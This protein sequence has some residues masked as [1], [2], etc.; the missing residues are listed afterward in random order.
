MNAG[1]EGILVGIRAIKWWV[2]D[3]NGQTTELFSEREEAFRQQ[4]TEINDEETVK[5]SCQSSHWKLK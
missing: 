1:G 5:L 3:K 2:G 4:K